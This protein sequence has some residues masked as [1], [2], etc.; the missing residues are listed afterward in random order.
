[1]FDHVSMHKTGHKNPPV[2]KHGWLENGPLIN[3]FPTKKHLHLIAMFHMFHYQA[4]Y[5]FFF[6]MGIFRRPARLATLQLRMFPGLGEFTG[7]H[8][9]KNRPEIA[10]IAS[11]PRKTWNKL[12]KLIHASYT[13]SLSILV[14]PGSSM[15]S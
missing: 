12:N 15:C 6:N 2:L 14:L 1:M 4:G 13:Y 3:D 5:H 10:M 11:L 8:R 7:V 9:E